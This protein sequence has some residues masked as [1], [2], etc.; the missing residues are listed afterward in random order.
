MR[1]E[2]PSPLKMVM[3]TLQPVD[4][5]RAV[6]NPDAL[7]QVCQWRPLG[8]KHCLVGQ[9]D[10]IAHFLRCLSCQLLAAQTAHSSLEFAW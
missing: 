9:I 10:Y 6:V 7:Q 8:E 4:V 3:E 1:R 5:D 2:Q